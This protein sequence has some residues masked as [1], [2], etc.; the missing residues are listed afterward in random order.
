MHVDSTEGSKA[1]GVMVALNELPPT[2][3]WMC[4]TC[5]L[6]GYTSGSMRSTTSLEHEKRIIWASASWARTA[7]PATATALSCILAVKLVT[8]R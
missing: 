7:R 2:T 5:S 3:W 8:G 6:P 4:A 1:T